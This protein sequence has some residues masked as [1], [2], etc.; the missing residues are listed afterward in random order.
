MASPAQVT[1]SELIALNSGVKALRKRPQSPKAVQ[2]GGYTSVLKGRGM[3]FDESR[4]YQPGDEIR[5]M[6]W[7]VTARTGKPHTKLFREERERPIF[8]WVDYRAPMFFATRGV[9]KSVFVARVAALI[10]WNAISQ[11]DRIG[12]M[13]FSEENHH[14]LK[15]AQ[16][17]PAVL[18]LINHLVHHPGWGQ[19]S[20][21][22]GGQPDLVS[23]VRRL[24]KLV[25]PGSLIYM[26][27]DFRG[28]EQAET[29][30]ARLT[31]HCEII[32]LPIHDPLEEALPPDRILHFINHDQELLI[33]T[34]NHQLLEKYQKRF[35]QR[36]GFIEQM[37]RRFRMPVIPCMT[38]DDPIR[39]LSN[40]AH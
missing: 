1:V 15:P 17:K 33:D 25:R 20:G 11:G 28:L 10:A 23:A 27:S 31:R 4:I 39:K 7:R 13:I 36:I 2:S 35:Q 26:L 21:E 6:D 22:V 14:E 19:Q 8:V 3:E 40:N 37:G 18:K 5:N 29:E 9:F 30:M 12:G 38:T 24:S 32:M 34:H 16:G